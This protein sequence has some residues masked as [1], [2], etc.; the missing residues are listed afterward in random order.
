VIAH[1]VEYVDRLPL[2]IEMAGR[3][4]H[5]SGIGIDGFMNGMKT[6][7]K[8]FL[9]GEPGSPD[10][11]LT[12]LLYSTYSNLWRDSQISIRI[13]VCAAFLVEVAVI[14]VEIFRR[15]MSMYSEYLV[16]ARSGNVRFGGFSD[17]VDADYSR[18][19][20]R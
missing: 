3:F 18:R 6:R 13:L 20:P 10:D 16:L 12:V 9:H 2:T 14:P 5:R 11:F 17:G 15:G 4:A 1:V 19:S 8:Q 7:Q